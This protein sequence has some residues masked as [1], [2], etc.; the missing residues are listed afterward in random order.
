VSTPRGGFYL[1]PFFF[2]SSSLAPR[3]QLTGDRRSCSRTRRGSSRGREPSFV[4]ADDALAVGAAS[5]ELARGRVADLALRLVAAQRF[6]A[7]YSHPS[8]PRQRS[9]VYLPRDT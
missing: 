4:T 7:F 3:S 8:S 1:S 2:L 9:M 5:V 6:Q